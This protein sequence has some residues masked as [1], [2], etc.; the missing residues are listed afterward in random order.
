MI[1]SIIARKIRKKAEL[2]KLTSVIIR[3]KVESHELMQK[4]SQ[5][6]KRIYQLIITSPE[7]SIE[8]TGRW[9][10]DLLMA[11]DFI[12]EAISKEERNKGFDLIWKEREKESGI[13]NRERWQYP[14]LIFDKFDISLVVIF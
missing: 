11:E 3:K 5:I 12:V 6:M 4:N 2:H 1:K 8:K 7:G 13:S 9:E 14:F 10:I